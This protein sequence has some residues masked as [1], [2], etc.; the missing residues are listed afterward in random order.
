MLVDLN[1]DGD[2]ELI[3]LTSRS[4]M[5]KVRGSWQK[6]GTLTGR[7]DSQGDIKAVEAAVPTW[8]DVMINGQ[9]VKVTVW[10]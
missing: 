2:P 3:D 4:I 1:G 9:R 7:Y 8:R 5:K 6:I 10:E